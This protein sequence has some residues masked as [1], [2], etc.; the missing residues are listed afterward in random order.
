MNNNN[1]LIYSLEDDV[2][3]SHLIELALS[4]QGYNVVPFL[5]FAS[6]S[7]AFKKK[8]PN[9]ILLD[10]MLP[11]ITGE[12][13]LKSIRSNPY[14]DDIEIIII[15]AKNLPINKIDGLNLGADDYIAKPFDILE[16]ISRV[17]ARSRRLLKR[18]IYHIRDLTFDKSAMSV[19]RGNEEI[20]LTKGESVVIFELLSHLGEIVPRET[21][22]TAL[23]GNDGNFETR[24]LDMHIKQLR[25][26]LGKDADLIETSY[27]AGYRF[28][29]E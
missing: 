8:K 12:E 22:F 20:H 1:Y 19:K 11:T 18:S 5:D 16:L 26:K 27:G 28:K 15:S 6:F 25:K 21:L 9:M 17:N 29:N 24:T 4:G 3:I 2:N 10:L 23:W 14:N 7:N 13:I